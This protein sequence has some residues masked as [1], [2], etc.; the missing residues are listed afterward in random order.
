MLKLSSN[1]GNVLVEYVI[2]RDDQAE[3]AYG[4]LVGYFNLETNKLE[5]LEPDPE[6]KNVRLDLK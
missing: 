5:L 6:S 4:E 3:V 2:L 1:T